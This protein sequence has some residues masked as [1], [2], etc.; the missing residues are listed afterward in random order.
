MKTLYLYFIYLG[1]VIILGFMD[2]IGDE[3]QR[4]ILLSLL[5]VLYNFVE[6]GWLYKTNPKYFFINPV[7]L[8]VIAN[9]FAY[10]GGV[11]N[12]LL[13]DEGAFVLDV[14]A[15]PLDE[16]RYW[17][18]YTMAYTCIA[19]VF[20]WFGFKLSIG[21]KISNVF[22][23]TFEFRRLLGSDIRL[24]LVLILAVIGYLL[25]L[26]LI[27]IG[28]FGRIIDKSVSVSG[29]QVSFLYSQTRFLRSFSTVPFLFIC[30]MYYKN[31]TYKLRVIFLIVLSLEIFFAAIS[32]ARGPI[33][34]TSILVF[35]SS[36]FTQ[37]KVNKTLLGFV[38]VSFV[39][40]FSIIMEYKD[41]VLVENPVGQSPTELLSSFMEYRKKLSEDQQERI[42]GAVVQNFAARV[43][44][45]DEAAMAIRYKEL[46]GLKESDPNFIRPLLTIPL[47]VFIPKFIQG[48]PNVSWGL[49][50]KVNVYKQTNDLIYNIA[51]S[52][53]GYLYLAGGPIFIILGYFAYGILIKAAYQFLNHGLLGF[54]VYLAILSSIVVYK[55][56]V[57]TTYVGFI[58][59]LIVVPIGVGLVF[60]RF[61]IK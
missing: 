30:L 54:I 45:V 22:L 38:I 10:N 28:L 16:E 61:K 44:F 29:E 25:K 2:I 6:L 42:Y 13:L 48:T 58:R 51:F 60:R 47:D 36:Y 41:F 24:L 12:F 39:L 26:Y 43:N 19:S 14:L 35:L 33:I 17:L 56:G 8:A 46:E 52:P 53:I 50:F 15:A 9:F 27:Q 34:I 32:G 20:M 37:E 59:M 23:Y 11:S 49:W 57:A 21:R 31:R 7:V 3:H 1:I 5:L 40:A 55:T 18:N 4:F